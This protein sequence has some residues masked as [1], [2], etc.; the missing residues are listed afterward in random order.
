MARKN[1]PA[2]NISPKIQVKPIAKTDSPIW[3]IPNEFSR[4]SQFLILGAIIL[5]TFLC[6]ARALNNDFTNWDDD[7]YVTK[8]P[9]VKT[10]SAENFKK[11]M[12]PS[13][14]VALNY[15]PITVLSL[16]LNYK[17]SPKPAGFILTN[18]I[19]HLLNTLLV[20]FFFNRLTEG[21]FW[22]AAISA[23]WFGIHPMH[24]ESVA[25][26]SER[27]DVLYV[28]FL[29]LGFI[30]YLSYL[31]KEKYGY[32]ALAFVCFLASCLS[33]AMATPF[34]ILLLLIDFL[35]NRDLKNAKIW[36]EKTPFFI[37]AFWIGY[38]AVLL[39]K[40]SAISDFGGVPF[41]F[42]FMFASYGLF[43]YVFKWIFPY[44]F[45][46]FYPYPLRDASQN[47]PAFYYLVPIFAL[48]VIVVPLWW[49]Y[50]KSKE[51][52][53]VVA[54]GI[55]FFLISIA[56]VLQ[57]VS[58][59]M[60]IMADRYSYLA[61]IGLLF[62]IAYFLNEFAEK[63]P[64]TMAF[65]VVCYSLILGI[66]TFQQVGTWKNS[67]TLWANSIQKYPRQFYLP[68]Y[69]R[70]KYLVDEKRDEEAF[71]DLQLMADLI[72]NGGVTA[73]KVIKSSGFNIYGGLLGKRKE[74]E[75]AI[76]YLNQAIETD[77]KL[78]EAYLNRGITYASM[79]QPDKASP[80]FEKA[81][82]LDSLSEEIHKNRASFLKESKQ[83]D[84]AINAYNMLLSKFTSQAE[85]YF[86]RG[87]S[88]YNLQNYTEAIKDFEEAIRLKPDYG[89][90]YY[91]IS[92]CYYFLKNN[93]KALVFAQKAVATGYNLPAN[94][95]DLLK[96]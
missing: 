5:L 71:N 76:K 78:P 67:E 11:I 59:G 68:Y 46:N 49:S 28:F 48:A 25:W 7:A 72:E 53:K 19:F 32:L 33:K 62:I 42:K 13:T 94:Y 90:A 44:N 85:Y 43:M 93:E 10:I 77:P 29:L 18:I 63:S 66:M 38:N 34:P 12:Q 84:K 81:F 51:N 35:R 74:Y 65:F 64:K 87:F 9:L 27:K 17:I 73:N 6:Y 82:Q 52:F 30:S 36:L 54:F 41:S 2:K 39:Q 50:R 31:S 86:S 57:F 1:P 95:L 24:V 47:L 91:D 69:G 56:L 22:L 89:D 21:K 26:I 79:K 45:A 58:V 4:K 80:D 55:A 92:V 40:D 8:N 20:F 96:K 16:A 37:L 60:A 83:F 61:S 70:G 75:K 15:H 14:Q 3:K 88:K 23:L